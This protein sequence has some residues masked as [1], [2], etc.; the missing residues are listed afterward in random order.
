MADSG[1]HVEGLPKLVAALR[2]A[3]ADAQDM[4]GLMYEIGMLVVRAA[5]PPR[6]T[7]R[8]ADSLRAGRG[9]TKAVVRA[10]NSGSIP[11]GRVQEYGF[12]ARNIPAR[13]FLN[14]ARAAK[15][16]EIEQAVFRGIAEILKQN[17]LN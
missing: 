1:V 3:G 11:Y 12:A 13:N 7:G 16:H 5:D 2:K 8:L 10:G 14:N 15:Q 9:K 4:S 6:A 17:D